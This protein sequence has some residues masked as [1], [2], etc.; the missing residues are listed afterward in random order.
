M[1]VY[2]VNV[3][4]R[5]RIKALAEFVGAVG[6]LSLPFALLFVGRIMNLS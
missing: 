1:M 6:F 4:H 2:G 5:S 3:T